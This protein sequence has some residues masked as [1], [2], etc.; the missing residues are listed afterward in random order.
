MPVVTSQATAIVA[1]RKAR[2]APRAVNGLIPV[3]CSYRQIE[4]A[5]E[6]FALRLRATDARTLGLPDKRCS[7]ARK[8]ASPA[9]RRWAGRQPAVPRG[10]R[11]VRAARYDSLWRTQRALQVL[12]RSV[13][14]ASRPLPWCPLACRKPFA[15][16]TAKGSRT[17]CA[18][19]GSVVD[20]PVGLAE[21]RDRAGDVD[22]IA[23]AAEQPSRIRKLPVIAS[24][25]IQ[26]IGIFRLA[27][28]PA[29]AMRITT[30]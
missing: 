5:G 24:S 22:L 8:R 27:N 26:P 10:S 9:A 12:E 15:A 13:A 14:S 2:T 6:S 17:T 25:E 11:D 18:W 30:Q 3:C 23:G 16:L 20:D 7:S 28:N 19:M 29:K 4:I 21:Q 1:P